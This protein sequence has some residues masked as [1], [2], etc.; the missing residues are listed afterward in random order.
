MLLAQQAGG[1]VLHPGPQALLPRLLAVRPPPSRPP[2]RHPGPLHCCA[3]PGHPADDGP[4][5][6]E[7][8]TQRGDRVAK[9]KEVSGD[10]TDRF[11]SLKV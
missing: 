4:G 8:Q 10:P 6:V 11:L 1:R 9:G 7:E 5:G 3:R 2:Q